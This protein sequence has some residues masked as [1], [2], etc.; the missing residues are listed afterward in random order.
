M[1]SEYQQR[2]EA[3]I[4]REL[5]ELPELTAP[6]TLVSRVVAAIE[7]RAHLPWYRQPWQTWPRALRAASLVVLLALFGGLCFA[8]WELSHSGSDLVT[9]RF[10]GWLSGLGAMWNALSALVGAVGLVFKQLGPSF[11][12]GYLAAL[13]FGCATCLGLGTLCMRLAL[14]GRWK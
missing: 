7:E 1:N 6:S 2:L 14:A 13:A 9:Q 10:G 12:I 3:E 5:K 4:E 11:L 8:G